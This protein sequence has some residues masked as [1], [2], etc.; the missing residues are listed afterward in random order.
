VVAANAATDLGIATP[1]RGKCQEFDPTQQPQK[2]SL[3]EF[4]A[5]LYQS[6][7]MPARKRA[8]NPIP[9]VPQPEPPKM[10]EPSFGR[11][12]RELEMEIQGYPEVQRNEFLATRAIYPDEFEVIH[13]RKNAWQVS[14]SLT[15]AESSFILI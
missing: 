3:L 1:R 11:S 8:K 9:Q 6:F 7:T 4:T 14:S 10:A 13:G 5:L 2:Y 15:Q 12:H